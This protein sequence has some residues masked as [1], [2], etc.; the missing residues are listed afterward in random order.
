MDLLISINYIFDVTQSLLKWE[1]KI[2]YQI[3]K[4][5]CYF[6]I[7][8][9]VFKKAAKKMKLTKRLERTLKQIAGLSL[10]VNIGLIC[11]IEY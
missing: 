5:A 8:Y 10:I 11:Q 1:L 7:I 6:L 3:I 4:N 2:L 9:F